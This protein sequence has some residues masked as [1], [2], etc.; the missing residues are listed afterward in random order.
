MIMHELTAAILRK[1]LVDL[2]RELL[3]NGR[4]IDDLNT[5]AER[6]KEERRKLIQGIEGIR[7]ELKELEGE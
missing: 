4:D 1:L 5:M 2:E 6:L 7:R 3:E